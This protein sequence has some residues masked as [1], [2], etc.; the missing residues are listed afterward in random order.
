MK[1]IFI[2]GASGYIGSNLATLLSKKGYRII[3]L[4]KKKKN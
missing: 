1:K 3:C 4:T 2:S